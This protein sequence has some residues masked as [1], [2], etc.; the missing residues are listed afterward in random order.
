MGKVTVLIVFL[1]LLSCRSTG[2]DK[3]SQPV[4][5]DEKMQLAGRVFAR[6]EFDTYLDFLMYAR[7]DMKLSE[8]QIQ[9]IT[10]KCQAQLEG[11][12]AAFDIRTCFEAREDLAK[13]L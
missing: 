6:L 3:P 12:F 2:S 5:S 13:Y 8:S 9:N 1:S 10:L 4:P 7:T 11:L